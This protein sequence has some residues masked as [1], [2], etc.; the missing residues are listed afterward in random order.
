MFL[1]LLITVIS[2]KTIYGDLLVENLR[3]ESILYGISSIISDGQANY[4]SSTC[5][6]NL[7]AIYEG[8]NEKK[9]WALKSKSKNRKKITRING[10]SR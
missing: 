4:S 8:A 10:I 3:S 5:L 9:V 1:I 2:L 6:E 7:R